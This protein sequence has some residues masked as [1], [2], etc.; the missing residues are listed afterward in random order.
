MYLASRVCP[1]LLTSR[2][3]L[4]AM[5]SVSVRCCRVFLDCLRKAGRAGSRGE[6]A[7]S[8]QS[9]SG[10]FGRHEVEPRA[11]RSCKGLRLHNT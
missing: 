1:C 9:F 6:R 2:T 10:V 7:N 4:I 11:W 3:K 8:C 5:I